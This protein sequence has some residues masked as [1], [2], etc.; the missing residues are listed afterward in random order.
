MTKPFFNHHQDLYLGRFPPW[1]DTAEIE[2]VALL[3]EAAEQIR[4]ELQANLA[5]PK[6]AEICFQKYGL[7]KQKGWKQIELSI[8]GVDYPQRQLLFPET[9]RV[10]RQIPGISTAYFSVL[11]PH[12]DIALHVGDVDAYYRV[13]LGLEVPTALPGCGIEVAGEAKAWEQGKCI[14]FTDIYPHTAWNHSDQQR[15]VLIV[16]I[17]RPEF[18]HQKI[19]VDSG[20]RAT[21]YWS[22]LYEHAW[23]LL[24][25]LPRVITRLGRPLFHWV[26]YVWHRWRGNR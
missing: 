23:P 9:M 25:L 6:R 21:L 11:S 10:L 13:H 18:H 17:L 22:R 12:T 8:Y 24:E 2:G 14:S 16:D 20:V 3:E 5:D 7:K 19:W 1:N 4:H 15:I 26:S